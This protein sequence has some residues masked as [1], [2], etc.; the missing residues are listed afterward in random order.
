[1]AN[2]IPCFESA[3]YVIRWSRDITWGLQIR[4]VLVSVYFSFF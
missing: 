3:Y 1:M 2:K 4:K